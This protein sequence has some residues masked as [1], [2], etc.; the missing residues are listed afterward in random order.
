MT[1]TED[2]RLIRLTAICL[3]FPEAVREEIGRHA[4]FLVRGKKFAYYLDDHHGDG[5]VAVTCRAIPGEHEALLA[6]HDPRFFQPAYLG[7][8]GWI[9][10]RLDLG[11]IDWDEVADFVADSYWLAADKVRSRQVRGKSIADRR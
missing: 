9:G 4:A 10:L 2:A 11:M 5:I 3:G 6:S 7:P 8:R 1:K